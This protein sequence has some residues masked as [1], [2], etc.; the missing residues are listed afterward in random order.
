MRRVVL[1]NLWSAG[2]AVVGVLAGGC[3]N[4][5]SDYAVFQKGTVLAIDRRPL[6]SLHV[7]LPA[8]HPAS[9]TA[10]WLEGLSAA[11]GKKKT[12]LAAALPALEGG[13][14]VRPH[15]PT[16][17]AL[18]DDPSDL[19]AAALVHD[20]SGAGLASAQSSSCLGLTACPSAELVLAVKVNDAH[21]ALLPDT[22]ALK[23][24]AFEGEAA[25]RTRDGREVWRGTC[26][27]EN[28]ADT[29]ATE[30][31]NAPRLQALFD[32]STLQC[33]ELLGAELRAALQ[34][35]PAETP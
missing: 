15:P 23:I 22:A 5:V 34:A 18:V 11:R 35:E 28:L 30:Q 14:W 7:D 19:L 31:A 17:D 24:I 33:A 12:V 25:L 1:K 8:A 27:V 32:R 13:Q 3:V 6:K 2:L 26:M 9:A 10:A 20:L 21:L 4:R 29:A 16:G